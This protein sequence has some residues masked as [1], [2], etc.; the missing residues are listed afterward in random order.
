MHI[1]LC[2]TKDTHTHTQRDQSHAPMLPSY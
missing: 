1:I 2:Y